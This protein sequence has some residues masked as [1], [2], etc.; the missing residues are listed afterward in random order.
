MTTFDNR[1]RDAEK[2]FEH[3]EELRFKITARRKKLLGWWVRA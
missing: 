2:K 1:E 3:D